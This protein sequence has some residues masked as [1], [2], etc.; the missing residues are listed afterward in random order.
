LSTQLDEKDAANFISK[1]K[2]DRAKVLNKM[3]EIKQKEIQKNLAIEYEHKA[4]HEKL[5]EQQRLQKVQDLE[6]SQEKVCL[7]FP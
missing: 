7:L 5:I 3:E 6:K 4:E 1:I 2:H